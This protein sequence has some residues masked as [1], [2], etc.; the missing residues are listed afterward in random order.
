MSLENERDISTDSYE[1][2]LFTVI[3]VRDLTT[4]EP[5]GRY[6][7]LFPNPAYART[8]QGHILRLHQMAK[9]YTPTSIESPLPL[10]PGVI[11]EGED[12]YT[13]L[14]DYSLCPPSQRIQI[15]LLH[16]SYTAG[17]KQVLE[18]RGHPPLLEKTNKA[19]RS[20]LFSVDGQRWP[21]S[22]IRD[23]VGADGRDRG[24]EWDIAIHRLDTSG[25]AADSSENSIG[26]EAEELAQLSA[27]RLA[28]SRWVMSFL[29]ESEARRFIRVWHRRPFP[30]ASGDDRALVQAEFI[31]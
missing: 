17:M 1:P 13:L 10:Q 27:R 2:I 16:P 11:I 25:I 3:P 20:V 9:T 29:D 14:Q 7:I 18:Q 24:L 5:T 22:M 28:L 21:T 31:W 30:L 12:A 26:T 15:K 19:G 6:F 4:F 23:A 8:Y